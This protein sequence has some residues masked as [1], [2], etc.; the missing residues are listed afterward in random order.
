MATMIAMD[1]L[2]QHEGDPDIDEPVPS[3]ATSSK[4]RKRREFVPS[5]TVREKEFYN[6][7]ISEYFVLPFL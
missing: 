2:L 7:L 1:W 5:A 6:V 3:G 4:L